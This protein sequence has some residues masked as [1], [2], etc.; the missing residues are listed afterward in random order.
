M[1]LDKQSIQNTNT[2]K[3]VKQED[4]YSQRAPQNMTVEKA[5]VDNTYNN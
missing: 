2:V 4:S 3:M 5:Q 1:P